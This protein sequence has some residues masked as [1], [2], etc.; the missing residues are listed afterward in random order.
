MTDSR[1]LVLWAALALLPGAFANA[2]VQ[3]EHGSLPASLQSFLSL[4]YA[5]DGQSVDAT[6]GERIELTLGMVGG[7]SYGDPQISSPA[8]RL[9]ATARHINPGGLINPGGPTFIYMFE[10]V[11]EGEAQVKVPLNGALDPET[12]KVRTLSTFS[13]RIRVG[14]ATGNSRRQGSSLRLDQENSPPWNGAWT[15]LDYLDGP[16]IPPKWGVRVLSQTFVP[17]LPRL[18]AIEVE[19][20]AAKPGQ[21]TGEVDM[22]LMTKHQVLA[23]VWKAVPVAECGHVLFALPNGGVPVSPGQLY[24]IELTGIGA[25]FGWKY[26]VGG[27]AKG[28]ALL[29]GKPL[30]Q[31]SR[32]TF[33][34]RTFGELRH[35]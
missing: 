29:Q 5:N 10:A 18:T 13:V 32:S 25:V 22:T 3:K 11:T 35:R 28:A 6:V 26:V 19:L 15:T 1:S 12:G 14:P 4:D 24:S 17:R 21:S 23:Q 20:A 9:D 27:Y 33:L 8:I 31:N 2:Q 34:F 7:P 16:G 30:L